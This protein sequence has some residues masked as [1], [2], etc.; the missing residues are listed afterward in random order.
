MKNITIKS[1]R[2]KQNNNDDSAETFFKK[3]K[4]EIKELE[5]KL[6]KPKRV[7]AISKTILS[8][9][10]VLIVGGI[11]GITIDRFALPYLLFKYPGLNQ[12]EFLKKVNEG[13]TVWEV[14][15]E[16]KISPDEAVTE[17]I[18][19]VSP[20][21]VEV[22]EFSSEESSSFY[23]GSGIILTNDGYIITSIDNITPKEINSEDEKRNIIKIKLKNEKVYE[24]ELIKVNLPTGLAIIKIEENNLPVIALSDSENL[25]LGET[26]I[27]IDSAV[28][29]DIVSKFIDDYSL[30]T[31]AEEGKLVL[32]KRIKTVNSLKNT[33][34]GAPVL[35]T[36]GEIIGISQSGNLFI[37]T[38]EVKDFI[39]SVMEENL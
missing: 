24:T 17:A 11:G 32:Q 21:V 35:N 18:K 38:N 27:V 39:D 3:P 28:V 16:I 36:K 4:N 31:T 22:M 9:L 37:P 33:F 6:P 5:K 12:Y 23:K 2:D 13:T 29:T 25:K 20:S 30:K 8:V 1:L 15:K 7:N 34:D 14:I 26:I 19:K 10:F